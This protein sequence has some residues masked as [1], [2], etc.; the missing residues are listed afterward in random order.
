MTTDPKAL[1]C[2]EFRKI[3]FDGLARDYPRS[4]L[5]FQMIC[6]FCGYDVDKAPPAL[7]F[8]PNESTKAA[9]ERVAA[10]AQP[11][12][13]QVEDEAVQGA[14]HKLA[15]AGELVIYVTDD[16]AGLEEVEY[17]EA[18]KKIAAAL[19]R[20][21]PKPAGDVVKAAKAM[22]DAYDRWVF[23]DEPDDLRRA[24]DAFPTPADAAPASDDDA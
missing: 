24:L 15:K 6:A 19:A 12:P 2:E 13:E 5:A 8:F 20:P 4:D 18:F 11:R 3:G 16:D 9:W 10:L 7:R 17:V 23:N 21:A 1:P 14:V 22:L